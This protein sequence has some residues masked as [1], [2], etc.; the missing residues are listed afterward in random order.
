MLGSHK[1]DD[2]YRI[3]CYPKS[4]S[5]AVALITAAGEFLIA[6]STSSAGWQVGYHPERLEIVVDRDE[7]FCS[8][9]FSGVR[10]FALDRRGNLLCMALHRNL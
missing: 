5:L 6:F 10:A 8:V 4:D 9:A 7:G 3:A 1:P 2:Y